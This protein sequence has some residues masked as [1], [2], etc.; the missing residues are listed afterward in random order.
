MR[1]DSP[2]TSVQPVRAAGSLPDRASS[3]EPIPLRSLLSVAEPIGGI[4]RA[5]R[6][7]Q[8]E[9]LGRLIPMI[10]AG[11]IIAST[12]LTLSLA[13]SVPYP[14]LAAWWV[15]VCALCLWRTIR[16]W[17]LRVDPNYVR[18]HPPSA[19]TAIVISLWLGAVWS[20]PALFFFG[21]ADTA[22]K[23]IIMVVTAGLVSAA[24]F[25]VATI[26]LAA[27]IQI[28]SLIA[29]SALMSL[30]L[31]EPWL[32][33][34]TPV[35]GGVMSSAVIAHARQFVRHVR[36][37]V[38]LQEQGELLELL[39]ELKASG[40]GGLWE[41]DERLTITKISNSLAAAIGKPVERVVGLT[42]RELMDPTGEISEISAG[43]RTYFEHLERGVGFRDLAVPSSTG[44]WWSLSGKPVIEAGEIL[45]WRGV[46]S[47][48]TALRLSGDD[49]V[50]TARTDPLTGIANR[51]LVRELLEEALLRQSGGHSGCA[52]LLVDLDRFK[53]VNDTLGHAVGD[54][55]LCEV[56]RR[57]DECVSAGGRVGRLGGDEF[58]IVWSGASDD[59]SLGSL[60][61]RLIEELRRSFS[62]GSATMHIGATIGIARGGRDGKREEQLMRSADLALY[63]AKE[64][65]RGGFAFFDQ[66]MFVAA[67]DLRALENDARN[68]LDSG[69][70]RIVYQPIVE[71]ESGKV[72]GREALLRWNHPTRGEVPPQRFIPI[73]EDAGLMQR[74]GEW[75]IREACA[76]AATWDEPLRIAVNVSAAQLN[77]SGLAHSVVNAL[78]S[79]SLAP[80]RLELEVTESIF[81]GDDLATLGALEHL[82][83]LGVRLVLDDFGKGYSSFGYL[84][85]AH[86]SKIKIDQCFVRGAAEG[87]RESVA[88]VHA[89]LAL[90][91]GLGVETTA[92]GI[93]TANQAQVLRDF[94][95]TQLQGFH[96]GHPMP[97]ELL[98]KADW[99]KPKAKARA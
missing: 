80:D 74:I 42:A 8:L 6:K 52:L 61:T 71:A 44:H 47:D 94:G 45:G 1:C 90:A 7:A 64:D 38:Q 9:S 60:A 70:L 19:R 76:E 98:A 62:V 16:A 2:L 39:Q 69:A 65:G 50:R 99:Q 23:I 72:V 33:F 13:G 73:I 55:L 3:A 66:G 28:W 48:V 27:L 96:F 97:P 41:L 78:A 10:L 17:R 58:A 85:R 89:I 56:A 32:V 87:A 93:E 40:T 37:R 4:G 25:T 35:Y 92:E 24:S 83:K 75:V 82:R 26:P 12:A 46:A 51:L 91:R 77:G 59:D 36:A 84:A 88:I 15:S 18:R 43:M 57:L 54:E 30:Q 81:L 86:F 95:C 14:R 29:S 20:I 11:Q 34:L 63:R 79:T 31:G 49:A 21:A 5:I 53:L 68:A 67:E 22:E